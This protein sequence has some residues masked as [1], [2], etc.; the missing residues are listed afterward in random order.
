MNTRPFTSQLVASINRPCQKSQPPPRVQH[1]C[2]CLLHIGAGVARF[3]NLHFA[4]KD[5][6]NRSEATAYS[7]D[8]ASL[9]PHKAV[10][11]QLVAS[12]DQAEQKAAVDR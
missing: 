7:K 5:L 9:L 6:S 3:E 11:V 10:V 4:E 1:K 12:G 8:E 2:G